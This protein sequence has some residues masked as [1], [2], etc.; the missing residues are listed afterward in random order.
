VFVTAWIALMPFMYRTEPTDGNDP[1]YGNAFSAI[2]EFVGTF[3]PGF[4]AP[5][6]DVWRANSIQFLILLILSATGLAIGAVLAGTIHDKAQQ[7]WRGQAAQAGF[8]WKAL[9][10]A[11]FN[12][13]TSRWYRALFLRLKMTLLPFFFAVLFGLVGLALIS[14]L[15]FA[16][17][18]AVASSCVPS[19]QRANFDQTGRTPEV[20]F[21]P[22][23]VCWG[24]GIPLQGERRYRLSINADNWADGD[25]PADL[26]GL[27]YGSGWSRHFYRTLMLLFVPLRRS[28]TGRWYA[29]YARV[30]SEG[31]DVQLLSDSV[32]PPPRS[33][34][35]RLRAQFEFKAH[36]NGELFLFVNDAVPLLLLHDFYHNN[37][38]AAKIVVEQ[39]GWDAGPANSEN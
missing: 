24:S 21:D 14:Q 16:I 29:L 37:N 39:L 34:E 12:L 35:Q 6:I 4:T 38:G 5:W 15:M 22:R 28:I 2:P 11:V 1:G 33:R 8:S 30:G 13:R 27:D 26:Y 19:A 17:K 20:L 36:Q 3:L 25:I 31:R 32:R 9:D 7:I 23:Q 10:E 18:E